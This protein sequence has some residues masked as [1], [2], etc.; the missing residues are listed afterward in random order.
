MMLSG[1]PDAQELGST[2]WA[3]LPDPFPTRPGGQDGGVTAGASN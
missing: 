2:S 1:H 3:P